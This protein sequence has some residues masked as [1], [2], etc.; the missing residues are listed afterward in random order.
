[1]SI[2][3][4]GRFAYTEE[5]RERWRAGELPQ[6]WLAQY[7]QLFDADDFRLSQ[8]QPHNH[9]FEWLAAIHLFESTGWLCLLEKYDLPS[10]ARKQR[11]FEEI[12]SED[13]RDQ[14]KGHTLQLPDLFVYT[15]DLSDY[16]FCEVKGRTDRLRPEQHAF[17]EQ[18][19]RVTG[20]PIRLIEY[21][22]LALG[23]TL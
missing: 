8:S 13:L 21:V 12:F 18:V 22:E 20:K 3:S 15:E 6:R 14:I 11:I 10:H 16:F 4:I 17:F 2:T 5:H 1:M 19:V 9:F 23:Q 7:P